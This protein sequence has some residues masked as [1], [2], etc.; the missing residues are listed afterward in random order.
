M[1]R[2]GT[3]ISIVARKQQFIIDKYAKLLGVDFVQRDMYEG[4]VVAPDQKREPKSAPVRANQ[5]DAQRDPNGLSVEEKQQVPRR[6]AV[7]AQSA[8]TIKQP[9]SAQPMASPKASKRNKNERERDRKNKGAPKWLKEKS[10][11]K[12]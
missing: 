10:N 8:A 3:V 7:N 11:N 6:P 4:K 5:K 9:A 2:K 1:G 12:E